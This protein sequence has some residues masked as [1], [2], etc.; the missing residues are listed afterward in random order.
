[1]LPSEMSDPLFLGRTWR[2][3]LG[4]LE[5]D[6]SPGD[7]FALRGARI[8]RLQ[9]GIAVI[10]ARSN[11]NCEWMLQRLAGPICD[12]MNA[13]LGEDVQVEFVP[14]QANEPVEALWG[15]ASNRSTPQGGITGLVNCTFTLERYLTGQSNLIAFQ[16]CTA[17]LHGSTLG[18]SPVVVWGAP[19][20][21][22]THLLH[23]IAS[24]AAALGRRVACVNAEH[25]TTR[26]QS[27]LRDK[28]VRRFQ[29][30]LRGVELLIVD[31]L[32][33]LEGKTGTL[34][35]LGFTIEAVTNAG[36]QVVVAS[37]RHP[38]GLALPERLTSRLTSGVVARVSAFSKD[39]RQRFVDFAVRGLG[40]GLPGYA[41]DR[42]VEF[43]ARS[44]RTVQGA[45]HAAVALQSAELLEL[46]R[47]DAEIVGLS[48]REERFTEASPLTVIQIVAAHFN[49]TLEMIT[50]R[51]RTPA[52]TRARAAAA[53]ALRGQGKS[54]AEVS[55]LL[56]DRDR[57]TIRELANRG[58]SLLAAEPALAARLAL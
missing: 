33:Y 55:R 50:G 23:A 57:S 28:D 5:I 16:A 7:S 17:L 24:S 2:A 32:Q 29:D 21:G 48:M 15:A 22:K 58:R 6:P 10:E 49:T 36:G 14:P 8:L 41:I 54:L 52:L 37:E 45:V 26:Y 38:V 13:I 40:V 1:M 12:A 51:S 25:F 53:G 19:G 27:A 47:L 39:E 4:R 30:E 3:V 43:E 34:T 56:G 35:E 31:D 44:V 18:I 20:L 9:G 42:I 46:G 11:R